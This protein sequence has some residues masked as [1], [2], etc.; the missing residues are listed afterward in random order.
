V[1]TIYIDLEEGAKPIR[2]RPHRLNR[3]Y[4]LLVKDEIEKLFNI[5]FIYPAPNSEW[6]SPIVIVSKK[7]G[8]IRICQ[9]FRKLNAVTKMMGFLYHLR[10]AFSTQ[11][12][13]MNIIHSWTNSLVITRS[14]L[15]KETKQKWPSL[16]IWEYMLVGKC[17]L[18][19]VMGQPRFNV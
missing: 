2:Q 10:I 7:D 14:K 17:Y 18:V 6:V 15:L 13:G 1:N 8:R 19:Y 5:G 4:F 11:W 12:L 16:P 9:D 3:K